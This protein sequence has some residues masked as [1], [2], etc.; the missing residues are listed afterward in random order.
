M[1]K[2]CHG[3]SVMGESDEIQ[4]ASNFMQ[5]GEYIA[6]YVSANDGFHMPFTKR[7]S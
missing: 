2:R 7:E 6:E 4:S 1:E 5:D 3:R